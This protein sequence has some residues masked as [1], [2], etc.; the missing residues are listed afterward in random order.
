MYNPVTGSGKLIL[1]LGLIPVFR[2]QVI[3]I[4]KAEP[5]T[6]SYREGIYKKECTFCQAGTAVRSSTGKAGLPVFSPAYIIER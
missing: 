2:A 5:C 6:R 4:H 3:C 1:V